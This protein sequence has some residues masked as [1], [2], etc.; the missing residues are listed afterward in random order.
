MI[1]PPGRSTVRGQG[2]ARASIAIGGPRSKRLAERLRVGRAASAVVRPFNELIAGWEVQIERL[3]VAVELANSAEGMG[4]IKQANVLARRI[5]D[6]QVAFADAARILAPPIA[7][8]VHITDTSRALNLASEAVE[9]IRTLLPATSATY[10]RFPK[11]S[12]PSS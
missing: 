12:P 6:Q 7:T 11:R 8:D 3:Q 5:Y 4:L 10:F 1:I 2:G 9:H